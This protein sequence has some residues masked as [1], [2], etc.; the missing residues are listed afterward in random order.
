MRGLVEAKAVSETGNGVESK[1][2]ARKEW[3]L[4]WQMK[5]EEIL[6]RH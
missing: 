3:N 1:E 5:S 4:I 6:D 2:K